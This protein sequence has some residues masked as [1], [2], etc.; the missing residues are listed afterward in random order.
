MME[1]KDKNARFAPRT[2]RAAQRRPQEAE[3]PE[4]AEHEGDQ[5]VYGKNPVAELLKSGKGVDTVLLS[6]T[7]PPQVAAYYTALAKDAGAVVKRAH[8]NKLRLMCGTESHQ[9]VAAFASGVEYATLEELLNIAK[10]KGEAPFI[11]LSD[12]VEDPHN[13][14][15]I[16]RS[17]LLCGAHGI[18]IPKRGGAGVTSTVLKSSA[19]A[20]AR[21]PIARVANIGESIRRLK[22]QNI[23]VYCADMDGVSLRKNNLTGPIAL[24]MGSEGSGVSPLVKKLCDGVVSLDMAARGTGVDSYNVSVAAGVMLYEIM[25]QRGMQ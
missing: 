25:Q 11:V 14:G 16:I 4:R 9:G 22:E 15:A 18:V 17:A 10:E 2:D 20:A 3:R 8:T 13:L 19:G 7:M 24:V 6:D 21:L 23:F 12:G 5:L 1:R